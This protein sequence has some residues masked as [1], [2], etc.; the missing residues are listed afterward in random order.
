MGGGQQDHRVVHG[1][2]EMPSQIPCG[3][4]MEIAQGYLKLVHQSPFLGH[5]SVY[6]TCCL[7]PET[8]GFF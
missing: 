6:C 2:G 4:A 8:A 3:S 7:Q 5:V 1:N